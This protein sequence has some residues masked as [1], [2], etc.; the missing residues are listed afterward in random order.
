M[1]FCFLQIARTKYFSLSFN[2]MFGKLTFLNFVHIFCCWYV[3]NNNLFTN[4]HSFVN[5][6]EIINHLN[7]RKWN[8]LFYF[9]KKLMRLDFFCCCWIISQN[10]K[11]IE[12]FLSKPSHSGSVCFYFD[13][14]DE[15]W[16]RV[17]AKFCFSNLSPDEPNTNK[18]KTILLF[19]VS[20]MKKLDIFTQLIS[21]KQQQQM[22]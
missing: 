22:V 13:L 18:W 5:L 6:M 14:F 7:T 2:L 3:L 9:R 16:F 12:R 11:M 20:H 17:F 8:F 19:S 15:F 10:T 1:R 21:P 4:K